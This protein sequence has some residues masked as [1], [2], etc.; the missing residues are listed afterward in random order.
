[1]VCNYL[2]KALFMKPMIK[3]ESKVEEFSLNATK[4]QFEPSVDLVRSEIGVPS[5]NEFDK[6]KEL[7]EDLLV[8]LKNI[9]ANLEE[10]EKEGN[11]MLKWKFAVNVMDRLFLVITSLYSIITFIALIIVNPHFYNFSY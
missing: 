11:E 10:K 9:H 2:A 6:I 4:K 8:Y 7:L 3:I 1:M 5:K